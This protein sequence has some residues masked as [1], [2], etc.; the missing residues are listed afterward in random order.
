MRICA[1]CLR[2]AVLVGGLYS[3]ADWIALFSFLYTQAM[4]KNMRVG[5]VAFDKFYFGRG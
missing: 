5:G 1:R 2:S 3:S 4:E